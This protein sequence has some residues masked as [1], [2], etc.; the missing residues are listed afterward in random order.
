M[1]GIL[2][3]FNDASILQF[4]FT[5]A[6]LCLDLKFHKLSFSRGINISSYNQNGN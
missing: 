5:S 1:M 3:S 2:N 4:I 6:L